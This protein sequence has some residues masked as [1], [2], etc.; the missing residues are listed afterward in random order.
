M[1]VVADTSPLNYLILIGEIDVLEKLYGRILIPPAVQTELRQAG[2][3]ASVVAWM[4]TP[5][6]WL[7]VRSPT[8]KIAMPLDPGE[9]EAIA[10]AEEMHAD[11]IIIDEDLGRQEAARRGLGVIGTIGIL[12]DAHRQGYLDIQ[13]A[14]ERLRSTNFHVAPAIV[15][16]TLKEFA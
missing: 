4:R 16:R 9:A 10:L 7:E 5:P 11:Q 12:R 15:A 1:I 13:I 3:P 8:A 14:L 2:A 6:P